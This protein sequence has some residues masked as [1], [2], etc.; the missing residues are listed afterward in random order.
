VCVCVCVGGGGGGEGPP[1]LCPPPTRLN[2]HILLLLDS[3]LAS[4]YG[5]HASIL[6]SAVSSIYTTSLVQSI[7]D[8]SVSPNLRERFST[9]HRVHTP[10][11]H[12]HG[13][14]TNN[15]FVRKGSNIQ[16]DGLDKLSYSRDPTVSTVH[17]TAIA[18]YPLTQS[19]PKRLY[20][21]A[22]IRN[23]GW[24]SV[25]V[26]IMQ[27]PFDLLPGE[28]K[29]GFHMECQQ[30]RPTVYTANGKRSRVDVH[31]KPGDVIGYVCTVC[32]VCMCVFYVPVWVHACVCVGDLVYRVCV[33]VCV[34]NL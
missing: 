29:Y 4:P 24:V 27:P 12:P 1:L 7:E 26:M 15:Y 25:G 3:T 21:E 34:Y 28:S 8:G 6:Q 22:T 23:L 18:K 9:P 31:W 13:M 17:S 16:F 2:S 30:G 20:F 5:T 10:E 11:E 14:S 32:E 33:Y 19:E